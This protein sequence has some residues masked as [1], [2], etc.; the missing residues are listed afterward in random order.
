[1]P[2][3]LRGYGWLWRRD[4]KIDFTINMDQ[5]CR[6]CGKKGAV[7]GSLCLKCITKAIGAG[8]FD[9]YRIRKEK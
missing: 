5:K 2:E 1:M 7:N 6:R 3:R 9:H 4:M 8:E